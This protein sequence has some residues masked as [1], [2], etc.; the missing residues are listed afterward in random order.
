LSLF[1][2]LFWARLL[3][4]DIAAATYFELLIGHIGLYVSVY[5]F[6]RMLFKEHK[7][8]LGSLIFIAFLGELHLYSY[9]IKSLWNHGSLAEYFPLTMDTWRS[10][11]VFLR[12][13]LVPLFHPWALTSYIDIVKSY[14][15]LLL[16][17]YI[18]FRKDKDLSALIYAGLVAMVILGCG[19]EYLLFTFLSF[20]VIYSG[21]NFHQIR[22]S[23]MIKGLFIGMIV[24]FPVYFYLS[25]SK[26]ALNMVSQGAVFVKNLNEIGVYLF[27]GEKISL[28]WSSI[29]YLLLDFSY[30]LVF[31][32]LFIAFKYISSKSK[33][34]K[35]DCTRLIITLFLTFA[36]MTFI[37]IFLGSKTMMYWNLN[38]FLAP[39]MFLAYIL[40]G[41][42]FVYIV[43]TR[44]KT[45][46]AV[47][48]LVLLIG[49]FPTLRLAYISLLFEPVRIVNGMN[50]V[51]LP[52]E[53]QA[54]QEQIIKVK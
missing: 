30:P 2:P 46:V 15:S 1:V 16:C 33:I 20:I 9:G 52:D 54:S 53:H 43:S 38:R 39:L 36:V 50:T 10:F 25:L 49:I 19:E 40:A 44:F 21:I 45:N 3:H 17:I 51:L 24:G 11:L 32:A 5:L 6:S 14:A 27:T 28:S 48:T 18:V 31:I 47:I 23:K 22:S 42:S 29:G 4:F 12:S 34:A 37:P 8:A 7:Y 13:R 35:D 41:A 26:G